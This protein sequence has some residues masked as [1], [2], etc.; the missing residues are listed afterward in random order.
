[1]SKKKKE[2]KNKIS[3][4]DMILCGLFAALVTVGAF[5][6]IP[7]PIVPFTLQVFFTTMAGLLLGS[8]LGALSCMIYMVLGL[9]GV[10]VFTEGGGPGYIFKPTFGYIIGFIIGAFVTGFLVEHMKELKFAKILIANFIGLA[11]VYACG[12]VYVYNICN[13]VLDTSI[14]VWKVVLTCFI[15]VV[16]GDIVLCVLAAFLGKKLIPI[17]R[18]FTGK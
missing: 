3:T 8:K 18:V 12:M 13:Y 6:K 7:I 1:M 2:K 11:I 16:P 10:P 9:V 5:I 4:I 14:S 15:M 17:K